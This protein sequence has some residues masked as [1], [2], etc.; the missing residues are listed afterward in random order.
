MNFPRFEAFLARIYVDPEARA[1]FLADPAGEGRRAR[2]TEA[3]RAALER[4]DGV[5]LE[6]AAVSFAQAGAQTGRQDP[7]LAALARPVEVRDVRAPRRW[8]QAGRGR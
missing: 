6:L 1:R 7:D 5:G 4:I 3:E 8:A 2:L